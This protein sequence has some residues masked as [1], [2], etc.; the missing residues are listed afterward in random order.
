M[1]LGIR[2]QGYLGDK[3]SKWYIN[4]GERH[5]LPSTTPPMPTTMNFKN[6]IQYNILAANTAQTIAKTIE[7][8]FLSSTAALCLSITKCIEVSHFLW[9]WHNI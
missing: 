3:H 5:P 8:P 1:M 2:G 4:P 6:L 7:M 9:H